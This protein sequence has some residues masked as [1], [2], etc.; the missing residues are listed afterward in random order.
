MARIDGFRLAASDLR[1]IGHDLARPECIIAQRDGTLWISDNRS[2]VMRIDADGRQ[3]RVGAVGGAP[4]GIAM[5]RRGRLYIAEIEGCK[6]YRMEQDGRTE[7]LLDQFDGAPL[8][9]ANFAMVDQDDRLWITVSTRTV[10]RSRAIESPIPDGYVLCADLDARSPRLVAGG[11][12]FTNEVRID[13]AGRYLY[14]AETQIGSVTRLPLRPDGSVGAPETFGPRPLFPGARIDGITFDADGNLWATEI[15][16]NGIH[17]I[18]P[19]GTAFEVFSDPEAKALE[20][21]TSITFAG[22]DLRTAIV[23]SL[24]MAR[25]ATFRSP[26]PGVP[27]RHWDAGA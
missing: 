22:A 12:H 7:L 13:T 4:N 25:L 10:P 11:F 1:Y 14:V 8:G 26:V 24:R 27:L 17:V 9:S 6:V 21:P 19:D 3:T 15:T 23:G 5:D 2:A 20:V 16:R 18:R